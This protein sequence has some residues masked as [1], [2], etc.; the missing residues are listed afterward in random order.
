MP[1]GGGGG[2]GLP[3]HPAAS[4]K[5]HSINIKLSRIL[6]RAPRRPL[7]PAPPINTSPRNPTAVIP[8]NTA[9]DASGRVLLA[10]PEESIVGAPIRPAL[11]RATVLILTMTVPFAG[12]VVV[13]SEHEGKS[14]EAVIVAACTEQLRVIFWPANA[15]ALSKAIVWG[16]ML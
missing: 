7:L 13:L 1:G 12:K 10:G 14:G 5:T 9:D 11:L 8:R 3:P 2:A 6:A 16:G 15:A 4:R